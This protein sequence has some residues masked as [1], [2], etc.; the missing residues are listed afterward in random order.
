M[1]SD[2]HTSARAPAQK[3]LKIASCVGVF[4]EGN[5]DKVDRIGKPKSRTANGRRSII[6]MS[7][8]VAQTYLINHP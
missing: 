6:A 7:A 8:G 4:N 1:L 5:M 3:K 2:T